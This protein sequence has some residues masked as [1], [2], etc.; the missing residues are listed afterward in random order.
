MVE[1]KTIYSWRIARKRGT[2]FLGACY[3]LGMVVFFPLLVI[4]PLFV[5]ALWWSGTAF[6]IGVCALLISVIALLLAMGMV[7]GVFHSTRRKKLEGVGNTIA[8][9]GLIPGI[10]FFLLSVHGSPLT[11]GFT[12]PNDPSLT[13]SFLIISDNF[14]KV[15]L[16]LQR[17][18]NF[19]ILQ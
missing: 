16:L 3:A 6:W 1:S 19:K 8:F 18:F 7:A 13:Q 12:S 9:D 5:I 15:L 17:H 4:I 2:L 11:S 14:F 10:S